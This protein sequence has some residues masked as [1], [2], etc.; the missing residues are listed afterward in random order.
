MFDNKANRTELSELGEFGLINHLTSNIVLK[1]PAS[2]AGVG[3]DAAVIDPEGKM[4]VLT[5]DMLV[6]N[7]HFDL[8]YVPLKH[9][10]YKAVVVNQSDVFAM[11]ACPKQIVVSFTQLGYSTFDRNHTLL[12]APSGNVCG[13]VGK[14]W[15]QEIQSQIFA[16]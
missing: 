13:E 9:L 11:N 12:D 7:V 6:E 16:N 2:L 3:D 14:I 15:E 5:T 1:H 8:S 10:G 4:M